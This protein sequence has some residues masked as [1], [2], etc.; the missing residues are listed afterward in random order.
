MA[1]GIRIS[2]FD[3]KPLQATLLS[4]RLANRE[5]QAN[6]RKFT[7]TEV[8][9]DWQAEVLDR[10]ETRLE[11]RVLADTARVRV[12]NQNVMLQ[13]AMIGR[14]MA[15]GA[16]PSE[17]ARATEFG[18]NRE[19]KATYTAHRHGK[20]YRVTRRTRAQFR[21]IRRKGYV[22]YQ[23]AQK[24]IPR[25]AS[26]WVQTTMRTILDAIDGGK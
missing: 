7:K 15:G 20:P 17:I 4:I 19:T 13:S 12:S 25:Y 6:I 5:V 23:A 26:L 24:M 9:P 14:K 21:P 10:T 8:S 3:S 16:K 18:A 22:V 2:V 11:V 1:G